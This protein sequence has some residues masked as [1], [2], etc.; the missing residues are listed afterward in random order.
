[1]NCAIQD[2]TITLLEKIEKAADLMAKSRM[3]NITS[4]IKAYI[5]GL[6]SVRISNKREYNGP[7]Y[8]VSTWSE[9]RCDMHQAFMVNDHYMY[10]KYE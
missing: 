3:A 4:F 8:L 9:F 10:T 7:I 6:R 2:Y 1:M 5:T